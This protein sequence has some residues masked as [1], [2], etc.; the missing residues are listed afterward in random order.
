MPLG[1]SAASNAQACTTKMPIITVILHY[2]KFNGQL[3]QI[4]RDCRA[5]H[6]K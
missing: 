2:K 6:F 1:A 5:S 4:W 3:A